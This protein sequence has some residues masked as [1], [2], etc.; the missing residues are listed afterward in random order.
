MKSGI[1]KF[2]SWVG[3]RETNWCRS[4]FNLMNI[5][6]FQLWV[7]IL[8]LKVTEILPIRV[9]FVLSCHHFFP[10]SFLSPSFLL[11]FCL[12]SPLNTELLSTFC[13]HRHHLS[14][15]FWLCVYC[16]FLN[17][18]CFIFC[19]KNVIQNFSGAL[20]KRKGE[21]SLTSVIWSVCI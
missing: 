13:M 15:S 18:S 21:G 7:M 6:S 5:Y 1:I 14:F 19:V 16:A 9:S 17:P 8:P 12:P 10:S 3:H 2:Q 11:P 4:Y 20:E